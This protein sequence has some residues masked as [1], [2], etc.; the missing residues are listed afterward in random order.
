MTL[1]L[2]MVNLASAAVMVHFGHSELATF[3]A[4]VAGSLATIMVIEFTDHRATE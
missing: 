1:V 2:F 4:F 3:N